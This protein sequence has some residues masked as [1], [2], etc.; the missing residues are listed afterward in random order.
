MKNKGFSHYS[1]D[2]D[3]EG[4]KTLDVNENNNSEVFSRN[5]EKHVYKPIRYST[6]SA[7]FKYR[8]H[9]T[10]N[11]K[12]NK[13]INMRNWIKKIWIFKGVKVVAN[14]STLEIWIKTKKYKSPKRMIYNAWNKADKIRREF[15]TWQQVG[16]QPIIGPQD[17]GLHRAHIVVED[18]QISTQLLPASDKPGSKRSG[19][20]FDESHPE[21]A[22]F[23]GPE[24]VKAA[25]GADFVFCDF[26]QEYQELKLK[27]NLMEAESRVLAQGVTAIIR[28]LEK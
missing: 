12:P 4:K 1:E 3:G 22:E 7:L 24:S 18:K 23:T 27:I 10:P 2:Y 21:K 8:L 9:G 20:T 19:L 13:I 25:Y 14:L 17:T 11:R 6:H 26:P 15:S 28:R 16:L 5:S